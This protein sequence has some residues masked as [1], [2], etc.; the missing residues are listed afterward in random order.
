MEELANE[1]AIRYKD[2]IVVLDAPPLLSTPEAQVLT[3]LVGQIV[4]VVESVKSP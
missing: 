2:R 1:F 4:E 3:G